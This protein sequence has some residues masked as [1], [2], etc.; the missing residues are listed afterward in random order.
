MTNGGLLIEGLR[1]HVNDEALWRELDDNA[2]Y[3]DNVWT[4]SPEANED[5]LMLDL[6]NNQT[7]CG[8]RGH[9]AVR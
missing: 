7:A 8:R 5:Y 1:Y 3:L 6:I 2:V 9:P 4:K